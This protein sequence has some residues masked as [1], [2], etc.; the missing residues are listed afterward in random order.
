MEQSNVYVVLDFWVTN[1][2]YCHVATVRNE[3]VFRPAYASAVHPTR[4]NGPAE[5]QSS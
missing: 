4:Y 3:I 2:T 5:V 1:S